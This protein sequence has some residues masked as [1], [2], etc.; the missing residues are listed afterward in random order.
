MTKVY[1]KK[2][3]DLNGISDINDITYKMLEK[4]I[5]ENNIE[6][7][8][9]VPIKVHFGEKGNTTYVTPD[10]YEGIRKYLKDNN[11][12]SCYIETNVL[13]KGSR[14]KTKDHIETA[15]EHG[16]TDLDIVIAD[17]DD[18]EPYKEVS[19]DGKHFTKCKIGT[20]YANYSQ[21]IIASHFK[22]HISAGAGGS[23]KQLAMG[24]ASRAGKL[25]QHSENIPQIKK[26]K[27]VACGNCIDICPVSAI[28][29]E[30]NAIIDSSKCIGC[31]SCVSS[32]PFNA[33]GNTF[34][35]EFF[36]EKLAEYALAATKEK[37]NIYI[38]F[39]KNIT[40]LCDCAGMH[41]DTITDDIGVFA[42]TDPVA[43]DK[44]MYDLFKEQSKLDTFDNITKTLNH[45]EKI[46]LGSMEYELIEI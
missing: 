16:F 27:C 34:D 2:F 20:K 11:I 10:H 44:A 46:G 43:I 39:A 26:D 30:E 5:S 33:I 21:Y 19:I 8:G 24:F 6:L 45:A 32:C 28:N 31:A 15:L 41:M 17:G 42:S 35:L 36:Q 40:E 7:K 4:I 37:E 12:D 1:Y 13:Y 29:V 9:T 22:G 14:T 18:K 38:S 25:H 23:I 3:K